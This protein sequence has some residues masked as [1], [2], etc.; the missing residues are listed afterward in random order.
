MAKNVL[1]EKFMKF[2]DPKLCEAKFVQQ[3]GGQLFTV[4][5]QRGDKMNSLKEKG[6]ETERTVYETHPMREDENQMKF[7]DA[8]KGPRAVK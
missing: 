7:D 6:T 1:I 2:E 8:K 4:T 3:E 5:I